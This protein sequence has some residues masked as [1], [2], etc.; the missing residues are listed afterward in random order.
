MA[1]SQRYKVPS[2]FR[3]LLEALAREVL[4]AQPEDIY[5]FSALFFQE[6]QRHRIGRSKLYFVKHPVAPVQNIGY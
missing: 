1:E 2:G 3:T 5:A 4:R 6:L